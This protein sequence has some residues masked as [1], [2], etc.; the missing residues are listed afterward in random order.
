MHDAETGDVSGFKIEFRVNG[1]SVTGL[2]REAVG[3]W[4]APY[5]LSNIRESGLHR[6]AFTATDGTDTARFVGQ[7]SCD[8]L[9]GTWSP[10]RVIPP[11]KNTFRWANAGV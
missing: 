11:Y 7:V 5:A 2:I 1:D 10:A 8:S 9:W 3:E 6:L 4:G